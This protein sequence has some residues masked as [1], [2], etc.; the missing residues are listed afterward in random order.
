MRNFILICLL[1]LLTS[2]QLAEGERPHGGENIPKEFLGWWY[3]K[4][5]I[6]QFRPD[7]EIPIYYSPDGSFN[8]LIKYKFL[9]L[10]PD[11]KTLYILANNTSA[12]DLNTSKEGSWDI[13][14]IS[15]ERNGEFLKIAEIS[16]FKHNTL[17]EWYNSEIFQ[18]YLKEKRLD[19]LPNKKP[20]DWG[21]YIFYTQTDQFKDYTSKDGKVIIS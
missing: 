5:H 7:G 20:C 21:S 13:Q 2:C 19:E 15:F 12:K 18:K 3:N 16:C 4:F 6:Y 8:S 17:D 11:K 14:K 9:Y 10:L 1:V